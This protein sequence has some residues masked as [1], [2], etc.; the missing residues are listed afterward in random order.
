M[1]RKSLLSIICTLAATPPKTLE[2]EQA[3]QIGA[4]FGTAWYSDQKEHVV[5]W[6][7]EYDTPGAYGR[8]P[9][10]GRDAKAIYNLLLC[11]PAVFWLAE[12]AGVPEA[13]LDDAFAAGVNAH[14]HCASQSAAIRRVIPWPIVALHLHKLS[15]GGATRCNS[16]IGSKA[17]SA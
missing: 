15:E 9:N 16:Q 5:R 3:L 8:K 14:K 4:G 13:L 10:S 11:P 7:E 6:L 1:D 17:P 12:A 2:L